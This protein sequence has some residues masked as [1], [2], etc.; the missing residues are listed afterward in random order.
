VTQDM[1]KNTDMLTQGQTLDQIS[2]PG[3]KDVFVWEPYTF[4]SFVFLISFPNQVG[5]TEVGIGFYFLSQCKPYLFYRPP[6]NA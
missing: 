5:F 6:Q 1:E 2:G 4:I 3:S